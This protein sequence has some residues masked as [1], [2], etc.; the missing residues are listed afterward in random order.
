MV[1][2][3][4][5]ALS[6]TTLDGSHYVLHPAR[7]HVTVVNIWA[8][9][10]APCRSEIPRVVHAAAAYRSRGV[11]V[12]TIDTRDG[13]TAARALL[14]DVHAQHLLAVEDPDGRLAISWGAT[15]VPETVVVDG[16]GIVRA[17]WLGA[18]SRGWLNAEVRRWS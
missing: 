7:G 14:A 2:S 8:A 6:G 1:G 3:P 13:P 16:H 12:V 10:C 9:W 5:P 18:V 15:G 17:R 11:R 4:A